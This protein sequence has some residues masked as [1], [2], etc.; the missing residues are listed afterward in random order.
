M[1]LIP[2]AICNNW[3]LYMDVETTLCGHL[4]H[5]NCLCVHLQDSATC[6]KCGQFMHPLWFDSKGIKCVD[7]EE[8]EKQCLTLGLAK[9]VKM[10][11]HDHH[12]AT[13][14][15]NVW[16]FILSFFIFNSCII[17]FSTMFGTFKCVMISIQNWCK[18]EIL[19][20]A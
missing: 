6:K 12:N 18:S 13:I 10:W 7:K 3:Y 1:K 15:P 19:L 5:P 11:L 4:Y 20:K 17:R 9:E 14:H 8:S 16:W 2:F